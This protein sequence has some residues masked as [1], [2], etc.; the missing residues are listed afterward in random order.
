VILAATAA[1]AQNRV[2]AAWDR[3]TDSLTRGYRLYYGTSSRN[4][5]WS[6]D[7]GNNTTAPLNLASG[8]YYSV[9]RAYNASNQYGPASNEV[10]FS[11][12]GGT[13]PT[14]PTARI[15]AS[16]QSSRSAL[17][18][19]QTTNATSA[20]LNGTAVPVNGSTTVSISATTTFTIVARNS[21]GAT[22]SAS[23]TVN[24][25]PS[26]NR[27]I[28][29]PPVNPRASVSG[30]RT[31]LSWRPNSSGGTPTDYVLYVGTYSWGTNVIRGRSVGNVLSVS[32]DLRRGSYYARVR[33]RN[34][35]GIS[36]SSQQVFFRVGTQLASPTGL[37]AEW[38]GTQTTVSWVPSSADSPDM[39]P[40]NYI[41]EAGTAPGLADV[42]AIPL[43]TTTS[44]SADVPTGV[45]YVRVRATNDNGDSDPTPD[46]IVAAP[47]TAQAPTDLTSGG[48]GS[49]VT[50]AWTP[51]AGEAV[52]GY[53][54]EAGSDPGLSDIAVLPVGNL[55]T[56]MTDAPPGT[57]F[58]RVR[59]INDKGPG[60]PSNEVV[61]EK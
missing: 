53:V 27:G 52:A 51:P 3:N 23:S 42:A 41:L 8:R 54:I 45:Y 61:I 25:T 6:V 7:V 18:S 39:V 46:I 36:A 29:L 5:Q 10:T 37:T 48:E 43:G 57:Y 13:T 34:A 35:S 28:P 11:V 9:V 16:L 15:Q 47:G 38:S 4:Y 50:L 56:F 24:I 32:S 60:L 59:A 26:T 58:V 20:T 21:A 55:T 19:W 30:T 14:A 22:A 49:T 33:A 44:F 12:G 40:T 31:T 17:V 2:T 1:L